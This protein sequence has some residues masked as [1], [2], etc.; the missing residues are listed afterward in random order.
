MLDSRLGRG[1]LTSDGLVLDILG[2]GLL[3]ID[4]DAFHTVRHD[5][6]SW[7]F[8]DG[9]EGAG[10]EWGGGRDG[11]V[12]GVVVTCEAGATSELLH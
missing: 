8:T 10:G 12:C 11:V 2:F 3:R 7:D 9:A 6:R 5:G 4:D 1:Q